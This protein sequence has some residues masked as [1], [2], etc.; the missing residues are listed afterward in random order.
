MYG[1]LLENLSEYVKIVYGEE[2]WDEIRK[3]VGISSPS[4]GVHDDYDENLLNRLATAAQQVSQKH[5]YFIPFF[6]M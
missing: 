2:K 3:Q 6:R 4:F 5:I 1:L